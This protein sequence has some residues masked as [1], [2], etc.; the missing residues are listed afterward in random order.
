[1]TLNLVYERL[2]AQKKPDIILSLNMKKAYDRVYYKWLFKVLKR[3][4]A[5]LNI[6]K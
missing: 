6:N 4:E 2:K 3:L 5:G 1:M